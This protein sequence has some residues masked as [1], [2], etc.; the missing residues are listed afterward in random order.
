MF[1]GTDYPMSLFSNLK[2]LWQ[3]KGRFGNSNLKHEFK[4]PIL[5]DSDSYFTR[6]VVL[7]AH[8]NA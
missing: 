6:L 3:M 2:T 8:E 5:L 1:Y 7:D 4:H